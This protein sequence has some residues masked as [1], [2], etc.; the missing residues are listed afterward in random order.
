VGGGVVG[1]EGA[2]AVDADALSAFA[3]GV[4]GDG[5]VDDAGAEW[6]HRPGA[7]G[8]DVAEHGVFAGG[9]H[10]GHPPSFACECGVPDGVDAVVKAVK[11]PRAGTAGDRR[12]AEPERP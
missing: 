11:S 9:Q 7:G 4:A 12:F 8:G 5:D 6:A 10:G 2:A 3:A 1:S